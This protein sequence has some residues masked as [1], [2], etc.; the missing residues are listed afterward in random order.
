MRA[1][2]GEL[3]MTENGGRAADVRFVVPGAV[4]RIDGPVDC[5]INKHR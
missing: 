3:S 1:S 5:A 2:S 4:K